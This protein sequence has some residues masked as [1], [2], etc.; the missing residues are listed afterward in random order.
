MSIKDPLEQFLHI[1]IDEFEKLVISGSVI[2]MEKRIKNTVIL[3]NQT[4]LCADN[5]VVIDRS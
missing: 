5:S 2:F 1:I 3:Q 4:C